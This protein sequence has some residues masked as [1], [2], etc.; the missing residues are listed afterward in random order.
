MKVFRAA[1]TVVPTSK[2]MVDGITS[3]RSSE[4]CKNYVFSSWP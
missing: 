4:I 2:N 3:I 1:E